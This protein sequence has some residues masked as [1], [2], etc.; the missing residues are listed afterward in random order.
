MDENKKL[1]LAPWTN[2]LKEND[3]CEGED[4]L[5]MP[6][7]IFHIYQWEVEAETIPIKGNETKKREKQLVNP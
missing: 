6:S 1:S 7:K 3:K 4:S 5:D 2:Q